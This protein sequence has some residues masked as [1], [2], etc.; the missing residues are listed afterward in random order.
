[1]VALKNQS[2]FLPLDFRPEFDEFSDINFKM[3]LCFDFDVFGK[4]RRLSEILTG[5]APNIGFTPR[6]PGKSLPITGDGI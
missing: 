2:L 4:R 1:V 6:S 3:K 5:A